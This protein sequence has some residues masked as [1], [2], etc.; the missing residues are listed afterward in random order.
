MTSGSVE[1]ERSWRKMDEH[2]EQE[3]AQV[4]QEA[5]RDLDVDQD[6]ADKVIGG[7]RGDPCDGGE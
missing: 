5:L 1:L 4:D 3:E 7:M 2:S 6:D